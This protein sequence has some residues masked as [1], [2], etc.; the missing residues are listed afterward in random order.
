MPMPYDPVQFSKDIVAIRYP[1]TGKPDLLQ[2]SYDPNLWSKLCVGADMGRNVH[3][4]FILRDTPE[5][6]A[7][8]R[9]TPPE[10]MTDAYLMGLSDEDFKTVCD[11]Y[12]VKAGKSKKVAVL[13]LMAAIEESKNK[14]AGLGE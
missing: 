14:A 7:V 3:A 9:G 5:G 6:Q 8:L 10:N 2:S 4:E 1:R 13:S 12:K 11:Q